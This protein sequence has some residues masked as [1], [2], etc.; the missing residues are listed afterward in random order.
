MYNPI[1]A[2]TVTQLT[3][4]EK[5]IA[6][7]GGV[8]G[9]MFAVAGVMSLIL[10]IIYIVAWWKIFKKAGFAGWKSLIPIYD[11]YCLYRISGMSGW[12]CL[13]PIVPYIFLCLSGINP[14]ATN[15]VVTDAQ[16]SN[17]LFWVGIVFG[18]FA[19]VVSIV[20]TVKI[21]D[22]FKKGTLFKVLSVFFSPITYLILAFGPA[23][24]NK[25][26]LHD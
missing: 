8:L 21:A 14:T 15:V 3:Q 11:Q 20:Q 5:E 24:Y 22:A 7:A 16:M 26:A 23:K 12:W 1:L 17:P 6:A 4:R 18:I 13:L 19:L 9:G 2:E 10:A 25:K